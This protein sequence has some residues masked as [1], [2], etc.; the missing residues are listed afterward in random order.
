MTEKII[1]FPKK[2]QRKERADIGRNILRCE[3][4]GRWIQFPENYSKI[5]DIEYMTLDIMTEGS[6]ETPKKLCEIV[7]DRQ[8]L[9]KILSQVKPN[10]D[11]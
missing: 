1:D 8:K 10:T 7:I 9:L 6:D 2:Y 3:V 5:T 4:S 11:K